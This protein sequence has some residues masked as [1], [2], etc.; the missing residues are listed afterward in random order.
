[1]VGAAALGGLIAATIVVSA[2][3]GARTVG[4]VVLVLLGV[5]TVVS[6]LHG[7]L[8]LDSTGYRKPFGRPRPWA[9]VG[10][11]QAVNALLWG[12]GAR[13]IAIEDRGTGSTSI[14]SG[15]T[16]VSGFIDLERLRDDLEAYRAAYAGP[17]AEVVG[18]MIAADRCVVPPTRK[19]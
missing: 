16:S 6:V 18:G 1:M 19:Q 7:I 17:R 13:A 4:T 10:R 2:N 5:A 8:I 14:L 9:R 11:I 3:P 15:F 12:P